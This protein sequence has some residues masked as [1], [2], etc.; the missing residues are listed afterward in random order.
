MPSQNE[1]DLTQSKELLKEKK[2]EQAL[3]V[4]QTQKEIWE[5]EHPDEKFP[6][7]FYKRKKKE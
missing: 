1:V 6:I 7:S 4:F 3:E 2:T 5:Q